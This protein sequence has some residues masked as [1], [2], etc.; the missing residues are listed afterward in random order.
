MF[1]IQDYSVAHGNQL[2]LLFDKGFE[3][4]LILQADHRLHYPALLKHK[5]YAEIVA[6]LSDKKSHNATELCWLIVAMTA[7]EGNYLIHKAKLQEKYG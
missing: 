5:F 2:K 6:K 7:L 1:E 4:Q 3:S